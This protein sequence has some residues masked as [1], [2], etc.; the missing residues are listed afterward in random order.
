ML[1]PL[2][3]LSCMLVAGAFS[4]VVDAQ[5]APPR[6]VA[7]APEHSFVLDTPTTVAVTDGDTGETWRLA[8]PAEWQNE[9]LPETLNRCV[10]RAA[11]DSL[12]ED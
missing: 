1:I 10:I 5:A 6:L 12:K 8:V 4:V 7:V 11:A 2:D 3:P 9:L